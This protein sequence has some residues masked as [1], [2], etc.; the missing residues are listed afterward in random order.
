MSIGGGWKHGEMLKKEV[1]KAKRGK[2]R[3]FKKVETKR[4]ATKKAVGKKKR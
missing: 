3:S 1:D 4:K 2:R